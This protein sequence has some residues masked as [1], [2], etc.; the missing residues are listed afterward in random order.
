MRTNFWIYTKN[1]RLVSVNVS[2]MDHPEYPLST[3]MGSE[4]RLDRVTSKI[5]LSINCQVR[6]V[7][8]ARDTINVKT[9]STEG[10]DPE[11]D[12]LRNPVPGEVHGDDSDPTSPF[13][14][15]ELLWK[16]GGT[17]S[18]VMKSWGSRRGVEWGWVLDMLTFRK[19]QQITRELSLD[20]TWGVDTTRWLGATDTT[21]DPFLPCPL[22]RLRRKSEKQYG[23]ITH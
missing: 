8:V 6:G 13:L 21:R 14:P 20:S 15:L 5:S 2:E 1:S 23:N 9:T 4:P 7:R 10:K 11:K 16:R 17:E 18:R 22:H 19:Q 12:T 3:G